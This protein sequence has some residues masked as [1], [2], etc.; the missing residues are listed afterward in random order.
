MTSKEIT[1]AL[2]GKWFGHRGRALC[3]VC[4]G[5]K[6][7]PPFA[8]T[9]GQK[10]PLLYCFKGCDFRSIADA[11]RCLSL[12]GAL[13][14]QAA[15]ANLTHFHKAQAEDTKRKADQ[16]KRVWLDSLPIAGSPASN[17]LAGR[18][19]V[20][21][22]DNLACHSACWH[23]PTAH[24]YPAMVARIEGGDGFAIHR[25]YLTE[26]GRKADVTPAKMML[27]GAKGGA[28]RLRENTG[29]LLIGEGI[30]STLSASA[31]IP[32]AT[33][34]AWASLS[35]SGMMAV[36]LPESTRSLIVAVDGE[37]AGRSA[38]RCLARRATGLG[39]QVSIADPGD[40]ADFN[41][42]ATDE[43]AQ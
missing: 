1:I 4:G 5:S 29:P 21:S 28:V 14:E 24:R 13:R 38:G 22:A 27:G 23:G 37:D 10:G 34:S 40:G 42:L 19:I 18:G 17:Y 25:T 36:N 33:G 31:L 26:D 3:P 41:D 7:N 15:G 9:E 11:L 2:G 8:I 32:E 12:D 30:E 43:V 16:A 20:V 6:H 39:W 35:T